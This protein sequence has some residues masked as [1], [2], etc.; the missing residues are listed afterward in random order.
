MPF[1]DPGAD[2]PI[3]QRAAEIAIANGMTLG[4]VIEQ[5][6]EARQLG[7]K[8]P[9]MFLSYF[10]PIFSFGYEKFCAAATEAGVNGV[11]IVD[12]P[13]EAGMDSYRIARKAGL[14]IVLL[15]SPTTDPA[16][17]PLY[18]QL[19][20]SFLYHISRLSVTGIQQSLSNT[21]EQEV[22]S[23][24][25]NMPNIKIAVGFGIS[26]V[27]HARD[28]SKIADGVIIGSKL[29]A[30]LESAGIHEFRNLAKNLADAIHGDVVS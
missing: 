3:N 6:K 4:R 26:S 21:L 25:R 28:V 24:R 2:G 17:L 23:L 27:E 7:C 14:E 29:V 11:L 18:A 12:L 30:T 15:T 16:R 1:S 10:N 22:I 5:V 20:P 8:T 13:P 9:I 19:E